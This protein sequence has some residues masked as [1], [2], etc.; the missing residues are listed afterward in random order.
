MP[1]RLP[2]KQW[3]LVA[4]FNVAVLC[5]LLV[6]METLGQIGYFVAHGYPLFRKQ[7]FPDA[8]HQPFEAHPFLAVWP[9]KNVRVVQFGNTVTL[10][11]MHTRSTGADKSDPRATKIAV[12]GGSTTFGVG[13]T[14]SDTWPWLLQSRLGKGYQVTNYGVPGYSTAEN[15]I[16]MAL[17]VPESRPDVIVA[18]EGWNDIRNYHDT[19]L[20]PDYFGAGMGQYSNLKILPPG[21]R[22][23][24]A[25]LVE[26]SAIFRFAEIV[27]SKLPRRAQT[28]ARGPP[29][30][31]PDPRVDSLYLRN[32][33]LIRTLAR[34]MGAT[35]L[36]VPQVLNAAAFRGKSGSRPWT[37][38]IEN[39]ALPNLLDRFNLILSQVC[40]PGEPDCAVVS[41]TTAE[42]W[43][44]ED[45][46][47]D[48][49]FSRKGGEKLVTL[50]A[51]HLSGRQIR[52]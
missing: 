39:G 48:G 7:E 45:F 40:Q 21:P 15:V 13:V 6:G 42:H 47:D 37:P 32:L 31:T 8:L 41:E 44:P 27:A 22:P 52:H 30:R 46:V 25:R 36:F 18:Y 12:L 20:R 23:L 28:A 24:F 38:H 4:L 19:D 43:E 35:L 3:L 2:V 10:T 29:L 11:D 33:T 14:D 9:R 51:K 26:I 17:I 49:H 16:Q 34:Q 5:V 50:I 1:R